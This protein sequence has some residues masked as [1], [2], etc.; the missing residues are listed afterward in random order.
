MEL[1]AADPKDSAA[2]SGEFWGFTLRSST[3]A[4]RSLR[5]PSKE[6][7]RSGKMTAMSP[8]D[9]RALKKQLG[10]N[11]KELASVLG[12]AQEDV[13]AWERGERFPTKRHV[14]AMRTLAERGPSSIV[15]A[16]K[17]RHR[18]K[19]NEDE[20]LEPLEDPAFW[21]LFRKLLAHGALRREAYALAERYSE[22][23]QDKT[24]PSPDG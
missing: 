18:P 22:P 6:S 2:R 1:V 13:V 9:V 3:G 4:R 7:R 21:S 12:V 11:A 16:P 24:K 8:E 5:P 10:C 20:G 15:R 17:P 14:D 23:A 19:P